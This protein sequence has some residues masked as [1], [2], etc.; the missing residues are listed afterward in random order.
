M[1]NKIMGERIAV[2]VTYRVVGGKSYTVLVDDEDNQ[3]LKLEKFDSLENRPPTLDPT[4]D[5]GI[6]SII[7]A[8]HY[9]APQLRRQGQV[10][11][12]TTE[13]PET[14]ERLPLSR[15]GSPSKSR[16]GE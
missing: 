4:D 1:S 13:R 2:T 16:G 10:N 11:D 14:T 8:R 5:A 9:Y 12:M 3:Y 7:H 15:P 6:A